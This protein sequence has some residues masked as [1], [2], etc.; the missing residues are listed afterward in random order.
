MNFYHKRIWIKGKKSPYLGIN[1]EEPWKFF[2]FIMR[3][4]F[5]CMSKFQGRRVDKECGVRPD[6][7]KV[8]FE[9]KSMDSEGFQFEI[10]FQSRIQPFF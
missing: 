6:E 5:C 4:H 10:Y 9:E 2:I 7:R 8:C 3:G 1:F